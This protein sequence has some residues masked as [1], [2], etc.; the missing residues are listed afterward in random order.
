MEYSCS[1]PT[2]ERVTIT[3]VKA[4][5]RCGS[6]HGLAKDTWTGQTMLNY[7]I[8]CVLYMHMQSRRLRVEGG[9]RSFASLIWQRDPSIYIIRIEKTRE[10]RIALS[11]RVSRELVA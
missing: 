8:Y 1:N 11:V 2:T 7:P 10:E 3:Y 4:N 6:Q 5:V 9:Q